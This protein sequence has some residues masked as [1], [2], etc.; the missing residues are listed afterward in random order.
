MKQGKSDEIYKKKVRKLGTSI[1][2]VKDLNL[3]VDKGKNKKKDSTSHL[4]MT[5]DL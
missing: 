5:D 1:N 2:L 3:S 4:L